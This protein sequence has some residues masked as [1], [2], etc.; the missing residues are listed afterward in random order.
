M[1]GQSHVFLDERL[2]TILNLYR[3]LQLSL[4]DVTGLLKSS[5]RLLYFKSNSLT[6]PRVREATPRVDTHCSKDF[7]GYRP[8]RQC[9]ALI[10]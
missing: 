5:S 3:V 9:V 2:E 1:S 4:E 10:R 7:R 8:P 6:Q